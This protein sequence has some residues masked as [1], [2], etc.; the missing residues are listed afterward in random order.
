MLDRLGSSL[1]DAVKKIAKA[2]RIDKKLVDEVVK[3]IQ[4]ALIGAD[5]KVALVLELSNKIKERSLKEFDKRLNPREHVIRVVYQ[6]LVN[7][8]G[9]GE[10]VAVEK[11][12]IMLVGLHGSG[13]TTTCVKLAKYMNRKG[14]R[15]GIICADTYRP[16]AY[17]QVAQ[18]CDPSGIKYY[19]VKGGKDPLKILKEGL[20]ELSNLDI[21]IIDT[22]GRHALE[23]EMIEEMIEVNRIAE[24]REKFLVMDASIGQGASAQAQAFNDAVGITG[25]V[26]SKL[27]GTAKGGG[28][29]SAVSET[30]TPI[31]FIGTGET[32]DDME[33]FDADGFISRLL[34]MGDLKA[35]MQR[36]EENLEMDQKDVKKFFKGKF[37]LQDLYTQLEAIQKLGPLKQVMS[38]L[39]IGGM[40]IDI[41][42]DAFELTKDKLQKY[43]I[44]MDSMTDEEM[45]NPKLIGGSRLRRIARGSGTSTEDGRELLKYHRMMQR[46]MSGM[47]KGGGKMPMKKL[48]KQ[49]R[50]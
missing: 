18:L 3:D 22:A 13:K 43:R 38:M 35:L 17:D 44:I 50:M 9:K 16:G 29:L 26:I 8:L 1:K 2:N 36:A 32:I 41:S 4:R 34:G 6:E 15:A 47:S 42:D 20:K 39:P 19:G 28:A 33:P 7:I 37:T 46:T 27:D 30:N 21:V 31:K 10:Q 24:P 25:V 45:Q 40:G 14:L 5:V 11:M 48:M 23:R 12:R 49:F